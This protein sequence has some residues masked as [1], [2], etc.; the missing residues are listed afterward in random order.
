MTFNKGVETLEH[1]EQYA[2]CLSLRVL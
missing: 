2:T 1:L